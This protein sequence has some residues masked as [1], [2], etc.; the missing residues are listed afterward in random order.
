M[1]YVGK[2][3]IIVNFG[4]IYYDRSDICLVVENVLC[5]CTFVKDK[6]FILNVCTAMMFSC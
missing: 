3:A 5:E 6:F 2:L 1:S 4:E